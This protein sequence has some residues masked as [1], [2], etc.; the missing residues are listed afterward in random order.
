[1]LHLFCCIFFAAS[2]LLHLFC[3]IFFAAS[4][5]LHLSLLQLFYYDNCFLV[6]I[7]FV[8]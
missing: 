4:F 6:T 8:L 5:L 3:C 7:A 1:L 2:F